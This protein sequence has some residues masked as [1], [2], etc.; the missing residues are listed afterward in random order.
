MEYST[1][2]WIK[3]LSQSSVRS[4][5]NVT[6]EIRLSNMSFLSWCST[7]PVRRRAVDDWK[8]SY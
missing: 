4:H 6:V 5:F 8:V 1:S 2:D 3:E 7:N